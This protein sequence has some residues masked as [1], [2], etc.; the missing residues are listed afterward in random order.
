V[1]A[2]AVAVLGIANTLAALIIERRPE[3]SMLRFIGASRYQI[4]RVVMLESGLIGILGGGIGLG[5]GILLSL[6]L[7]YVINFQSFGWTIQFVM[8][9]GFV[10]Q[11]LLFVL[12]AT[13]VAGLYPASLALRMDPIQ[14]IRAE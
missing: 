12:I 14:G 7:V 10:L 1:I 3:M 11:S 2:M 5:L 8:P 4:R 13:V 6:L 9:F